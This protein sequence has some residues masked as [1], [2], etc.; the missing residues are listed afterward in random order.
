M[1]I[2]VLQMPVCMEVTHVHVHWI[3]AC[4]QD[5]ELHVWEELNRLILNEHPT[6][7]ENVVRKNFSAKLDFK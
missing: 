5:L 3:H 4:M 1:D 2:G 6:I 7:M